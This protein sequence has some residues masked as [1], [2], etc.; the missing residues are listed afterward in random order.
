[1]KPRSND[2]HFSQATLHSH[3]CLK[4]KTEGEKEEKL[5]SA[6][7]LQ[8]LI[9]NNNLEVS[10]ILI[11]K[12]IMKRYRAQNRV[13]GKLEHGMLQ[14]SPIKTPGGGSLLKVGEL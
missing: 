11:P 9:V 7:L 5:S 1:M 14:L 12:S 2:V 3:F 8:D 13:D 10:T 6:I 4:L